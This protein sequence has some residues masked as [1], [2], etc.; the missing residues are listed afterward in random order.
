MLAV[1]Q[2][3]LLLFNSPSQNFYVVRFFS[4]ALMPS[5]TLGQ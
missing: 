4:R 2:Y 3:M 5:R 1:T